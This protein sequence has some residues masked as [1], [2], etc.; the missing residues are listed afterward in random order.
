MTADDIAFRAADCPGAAALFR[1]KATAPPGAGP[2]APV[3]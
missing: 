2:L 1:L 3:P